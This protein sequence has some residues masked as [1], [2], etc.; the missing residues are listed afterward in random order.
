MQLKSSGFVNNCVIPIRYTCKGN[1]INPPLFINNVPKNTASLALMLHDP[2]S[3]NGTFLHW[4]MW[5]INPA[6]TT[7]T[8]A[9]PPSGAIQG[10]NDFGQPGYG[11]PCPHTGTHRYVFTLYALNTRLA[12][13]ADTPSAD[14]LAAVTEH[15][16]ATTT[17]TG[18]FSAA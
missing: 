7:I 15:T 12:L 11:G 5:D 16:I 18:L 13:P 10:V 17:L 8:E 2:D 1:N 14:V 6:T 3:P 9:T 4:L